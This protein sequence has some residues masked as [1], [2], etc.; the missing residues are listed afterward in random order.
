[1]NGDGTWHY[2][3]V[4]FNIDMDRMVDS[5]TLP[6][7]SGVTVSNVGFHAPEHW[8]DP[9]AYVGGPA[10]DN[11]AW[12]FS[13]DGSSITWSTSTNP[14]RWGTMYNFWFDASAEPGVVT[15]SLGQ[16][17]PGT[18]TD[19]T[20]D[21]LGPLTPTTPTGC[22]GDAD[23]NNTIDFDDLNVILGN[24]GTS[25]PAGDVYP[26]PGGDGQVNFDDLNLVLGNWGVSCK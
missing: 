20:G 8:D 11:A 9:V 25:G 13:D 2:E 3:F 22:E 18:P 16:Y 10:I 12:S 17:K 23:G 26:F 4:L 15:A 24:W 7:P 14:L 6:I 19:L 5:F 1:D 21:T